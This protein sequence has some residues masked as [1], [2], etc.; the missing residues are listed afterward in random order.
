LDATREGTIT[1][2]LLQAVYCDETSLEPTRAMQG[3]KAVL[4]REGATNSSGEQLNEA[5]KN[6]TEEYFTILFLYMADFHQ[7]GK[8]I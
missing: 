2:E 6:A 3:A 4:K 1:V 5:K 8:I 7:Y